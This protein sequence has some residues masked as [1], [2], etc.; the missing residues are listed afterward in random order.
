MNRNPK[1]CWSLTVNRASNQYSW[2]QIF[3]S[4]DAESVLE[5]IG[6]HQRSLLSTVHS[7]MCT[8]C[9]SLSI[10]W[11]DITSRRTETS[12]QH[13]IVSRPRHRL[14]SFPFEQDEFYLVI[15]IIRLFFDQSWSVFFGW[16]FYFCSLSFSYCLS[17][18]DFNI[19]NSSRYSTSGH[20]CSNDLLWRT[21]KANE[22]EPIMNGCVLS[23]RIVSWMNYVEWREP[24]LI[25]M[26]Y[27]LPNAHLNVWI[28][29]SLILIEMCETS[30]FVVSTIGC[31]RRNWRPIWHTRMPC[32]Y[33]NNVSLW[34]SFLMPSTGMFL[35]VSRWETSEIQA[36][37]T[38]HR[39]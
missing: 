1:Y 9:V 13:I 25:C 5:P 18:V 22:N 28:G 32:S 38:T 21:S 17:N 27:R 30:S 8:T 23:C 33:R 11:I 14:N 12:I 24:S 20:Q 34:L 3:G 6:M 37:S 26:W 19:T 10:R 36:G 16:S 4:I 7:Q 39:R 15:I 29:R 2:Q 31:N 35:I